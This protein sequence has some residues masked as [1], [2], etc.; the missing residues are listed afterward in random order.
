[1]NLNIESI[2]KDRKDNY[3]KLFTLTANQAEDLDF[4]IHKKEYAKELALT[5]DIKIL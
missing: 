2:R 4:L 5:E 1:V 3:R